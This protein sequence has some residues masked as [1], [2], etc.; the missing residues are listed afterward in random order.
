M[1]EGTTEYAIFICFRIGMFAINPLENLSRLGNPDLN[2]PVSF[3]YGDIDWM[4]CNG[5][6]RIVERKNHC[7]DI[8]KVYIVKNSDH[9]MY[10]DNPEEFAY[11]IINDIQDTLKNPNSIP[12]NNSIRESQSPRFAYVPRKDFEE[13]EV[14]DCNDEEAT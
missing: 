8:S 7:K 1:R 14:K 13:E 4:D 12:F 6:E 5:G 10:M 3:F 11:L 9:H 2:L